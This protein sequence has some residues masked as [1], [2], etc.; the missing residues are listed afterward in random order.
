MGSRDHVSQFLLQKLAHTVVDLVLQQLELKHGY[1]MSLYSDEEIREIAQQASAGKYRLELEVG[2]GMLRLTDGFDEWSCVQRTRWWYHE[3]RSWDTRPNPSQYYDFI[4]VG[5]ADWGT[6][7]H[8]CAGYEKLASPMGAQIWSSLEDL[9]WVQ[10]LAIDPVREHL[11]VLPDLPRLHKVEAAM[12][13]I[14]GEDRFFFVSKSDIE[15]HQGNYWHPFSDEAWSWPVDVF[16]FAGS[17]GSLGK[18]H[19]NLEYMLRNIGRLDLLQNRDVQVF[20]WGTL[21]DKYDV[22]SVDVIQLDCEGRD[23]AILRGMLRHC[24]SHPQALPRVILFE[25][26]HLTPET[27]I[28]EIVQMLERRGLY[29]KYRTRNNILVERRF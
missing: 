15:Q 22:R 17:L 2:Q 25:A 23:C 7:A 9:Q 6:I 12:D 13:E 24:D 8:Y 11:E 19:P 5:T 21:C 27:E 3:K 16:D 20:D 14:Y 10:G 29:V 1:C 4:E 18:P 26:N 28:E